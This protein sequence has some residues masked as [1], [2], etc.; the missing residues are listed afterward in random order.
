MTKQENQGNH[1]RSVTI[2]A[3]VILKVVIRLFVIRKVLIEWHK[4]EKERNPSHKKKYETKEHQGKCCNTLHCINFAS[5]VMKE[6]SIMSRPPLPYFPPNISYIS[7]LKT[8]QIALVSAPWRSLT[9]SH[10]L[11]VVCA[12]DGVPYLYR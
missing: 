7:G 3:W 10:L 2:V 8:T 9:R 6:E 5:I 11:H 12:S 4:I 1:E